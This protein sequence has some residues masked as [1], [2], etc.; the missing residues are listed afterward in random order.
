MV[1]TSN[2][3]E[4]GFTKKEKLDWNDHYPSIPIYLGNV[5]WHDETV[6]T[7][8]IVADF[9]TGNVVPGYNA[10]DDELRQRLGFPIVSRLQYCPFL[11]YYRSSVIKVGIKD[12]KGNQKV[13]PLEVMFVMDWQKR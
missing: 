3:P 10:F 12:S 2:W 5:D 6:F 9:D 4:T 7:N 8:G 13:L 11:G 1:G